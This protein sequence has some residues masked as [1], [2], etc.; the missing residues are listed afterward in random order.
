MDQEV[1]T[2]RIENWKKLILEANSCGLPKTEWCKQNGIRTKTFYYWQRK[3]RRMEAGKI[4][5]PSEFPELPT[6]STPAFVDMT[7]LYRERSVPS[8][9]IPED[10]PQP[11]FSPQL[12]LLAGQYRILVGETVG[13]QTLVTVLRAIRNA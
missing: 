9:R 7:H 12:M 10:Q 3:I 13:E 6:G 4:L 5:S 1:N 2:I 11:A 8:N